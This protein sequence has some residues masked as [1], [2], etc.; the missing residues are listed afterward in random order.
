MKF[1]FFGFPPLEPRPLLHMLFNWSVS[2]WR[3]SH[4]IHFLQDKRDR[5]KQERNHVTCLVSFPFPIS[6]PCLSLAYVRSFADSPLF[7]FPRVWILL[8]YCFEQRFL[9]SFSLLLILFC[10]LLISQCFL[11]LFSSHHLPRASRSREL[12]RNMNVSS[13]SCS[14][15]C[16]LWITTNLD[17]KSLRAINWEVS[18]KVLLQLAIERLLCFFDDHHFFSNCSYFHLPQYDF[19]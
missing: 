7:P 15:H 5:E 9:C 17:N 12:D 4:G 10:Y 3:L 19:F 14:Y 18:F 2:I 1:H 16:T 8:S 11:S 6:S 13:P